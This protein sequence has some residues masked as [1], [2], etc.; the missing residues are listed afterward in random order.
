[1]SFIHNYSKGDWCI[2]EN[3]LYLKDEDN[4]SIEVIEVSSKGNSEIC[5]VSYNDATILEAESNEKLI[6][7]APSLLEWAE[8]LHDQWIS[9][10]KP[11]ALLKQLQ[12][13]IEK[14]GVKITHKNR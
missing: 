8:L 10:E 4:N 13:T 14:A 12:E 1:M 3:G 7:Q 6:S 2:S 11:P 5:F 9:M